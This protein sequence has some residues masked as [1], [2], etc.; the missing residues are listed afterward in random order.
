VAQAV[1]ASSCLAS[2]RQFV[3]TPV[4][5]KKPQKTEQKNQVECKHMPFIVLKDFWYKKK[6]KHVQ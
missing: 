6:F 4:P 3:Q 1:R 2:A 5:P